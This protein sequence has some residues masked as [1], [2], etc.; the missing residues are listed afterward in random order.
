V[1][2]LLAL[3][4]GETVTTDEIIDA[5]WGEAVPRGARGTVRT[6]VYRLR[7]ALGTASDGKTV[8]E[9]AT[10][11]Y[12]LPAGA[13]STDL[14]AFCDWLEQ[15]RILRSEGNLS[16][17]AELLGKALLLWHG[18]AL[19]GIPG[20]YVQEQRAWLEQLRLGAQEE[21]FG[22]DLDRG[23]HTAVAADLTAAVAAH[24]LRERLRELLML[25]LYRSG[26][27]AE[28]LA[29]YRDFRAL[30]VS[31]LGIEPG[32]GLQLLNEGILRSDPE[33][34]GVPAVPHPR[35][36]PLYE[37]AQLPPGLPDF[38]GRSAEIAGIAGALSSPGAVPAVGITGLGGTGKTA[39]A[40][41]VAHQLRDR[42]PD[43]QVYA[44]LGAASGCP[45]N[46]FDV[47][48]SCLRAFGVTGPAL[49]DTI[50][51]R[52][53]LWR[54]VLAG[55]KVLVVLDDARDTG[56]IR[57]LLPASDGSA[58]IITCWQRM[59]DLAGVRWVTLD[60]MTPADALELLGA[61]AGRT[62][63]LAERESAVR[64]IAACS[65]QPLAVRVAAARLLARPLWSVQQIED[66]LND[67]LRN[68]V[69][70]QPDC[71][72]VDAPFLLAESRL[73]PELASA[74]RLSAVPDCAFL[75]PVT[76]AI[77]LDVPL[78]RAR[79]LLESLVDAHLLQTLPSGGYRFHGLIRAFARR[80]A[81]DTDGTEVK[82][83]LER[84]ANYYRDT[85][86]S[87]RDPEVTTSHR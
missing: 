69:V 50:G 77:L 58:A 1:L 62:R 64:L 71:A 57:D 20:S 27:Q 13:V 37:P 79:A 36:G 59:I 82:R 41:H 76:T 21:R 45:A 8:P 15:A 72:V 63:V 73:T 3:R 24:P 7:R 6:Y 52:A 9:S 44:N 11:G 31:D 28:A 16:S 43:G 19:A 12:M 33:R 65:H 55:R 61:V 83:A 60:A 42:F 38:V 46:P 66:Q 25:A 68:P 39:L 34:T 74:F 53:A 22:V 80:R 2:G 85:A 56:Q 47:L 87:R 51:E 5:L 75:S 86:S 23:Q 49:P 14:S 81:L 4:E 17:A 30:L 18:T 32:Q 70:M 48:G 26:R 84:L 35:Q 67:D 40:V 10:G 78:A 29:V 54:T